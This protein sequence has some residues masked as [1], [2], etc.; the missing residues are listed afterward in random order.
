MP[1]GHT[2]IDGFNYDFHPEFTEKRIALFVASFSREQ[3][4]GCWIW[5]GAK[6]HAGYGKV[7][8]K[9]KTYIAHRLAYLMFVGPMPE[10]FEVHHKCKNKA[11]HA[12]NTLRYYHERKAKESILS[13]SADA[14]A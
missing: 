8:Y 1:S 7:S 5:Q 3:E 11:C 6:S 13:Q 9:G 4:S 2:T 10:D 12:E 14:M